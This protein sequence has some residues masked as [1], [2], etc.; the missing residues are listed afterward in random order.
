MSSKVLDGISFA[1]IAVFFGVIVWA[2]VWGETFWVVGHLS[3]Q[4]VIILGDLFPLLFGILWLLWRYA[5]VLT[6]R[7]PLVFGRPGHPGLR[8]RGLLF[9]FLAI[10]GGAVVLLRWIAEFSR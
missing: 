8:N 1:S 3:I 4:S 6:A 2:A 5:K 9:Y 7:F 10:F